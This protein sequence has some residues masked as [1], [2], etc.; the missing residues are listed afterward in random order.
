MRE[1]KRVVELK[2]KNLNNK[3]SKIKMCK[4]RIFCVRTPSP[5]IVILLII[6]PSSK[7]DSILE[8]GNKNRK[9]KKE[10]FIVGVTILPYFLY[11]SRTTVE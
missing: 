3:K 6:K 4:Y 1:V 2:L 10:G 9:I 5:E 7:G 11:Y 8:K